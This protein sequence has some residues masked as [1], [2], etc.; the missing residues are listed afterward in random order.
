MGLFGP[1][2]MTPQYEITAQPFPGQ[3][4]D[5]PPGDEIPEEASEKAKDMHKQ[6]LD[7]W[8]TKEDN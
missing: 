2:Q 3:P 1:L 8:N 5:P 6:L 4:E 7:F